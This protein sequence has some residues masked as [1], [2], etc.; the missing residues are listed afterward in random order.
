MTLL[1]APDHFSSG[2]CKHCVALFLMK[3]ARPTENHMSATLTLVKHA[4][5][6]FGLTAGH[7][8]EMA[9]AAGMDLATVRGKVEHFPPDRF[10]SPASLDAPD[11]SL[12]ELQT[13]LW[14]TLKKKPISLRTSPLFDEL[15]HGIAVGFP[16]DTKFRLACFGGYFVA[17]PCVHVIAES[18]AREGGTFVLH[19]ELPKTPDVEN[20]SGLS[21]GPVFWTSAKDYGLLGVVR[22]APSIEPPSTGGLT[23]GPRLMIRVQRVTPERFDHWLEQMPAKRPL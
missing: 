17:S 18:S 3:G 9:V 1:P 22:S 5:R 15:T 6:L 7:V 13:D 19:S 16:T 4:G 10:W 12:V 11:I 21:G 14:K 23:P 20:L 8:V 2:A